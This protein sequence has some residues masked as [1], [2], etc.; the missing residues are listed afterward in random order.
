[1][2]CTWAKYVYHMNTFFLFLTMSF[3]TN[4]Q[5]ITIKEAAEKYNKAEITI[6]RL[7]RQIVKIT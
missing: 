1:M 4:D 6:R 3:P 7:I 2:F 5:V